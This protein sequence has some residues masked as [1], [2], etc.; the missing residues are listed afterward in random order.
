MNEIPHTRPEVK[1]LAQKSGNPDTGSLYNY[2]KNTCG[3][4]RTA[5]E[6]EN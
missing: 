6:F 3:D 4:E 2:S 1:N 5:V